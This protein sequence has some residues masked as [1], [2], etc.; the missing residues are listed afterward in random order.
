MHLQLYGRLQ[1]LIHG[2]IPIPLKGLDVPGRCVASGASVWLML[3]HLR[4]YGQFGN[5]LRNY[6]RYHDLR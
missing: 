1:I 6:L 2:R 4:N 5:Y 3:L